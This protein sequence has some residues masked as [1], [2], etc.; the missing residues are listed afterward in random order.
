MK[1]GLIILGVLVVIIAGF[2]ISRYNNMVT[3]SEKVDAKFSDIDTQLQRRAD[4][5]PNLVNAVQ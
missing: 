3:L 1:K 2:F 4:L 5:I